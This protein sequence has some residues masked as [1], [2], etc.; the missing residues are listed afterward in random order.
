MECKF[1]I[2]VPVYKVEDYL[3][4]CVNS[5]RNQTLEEFELILVDDG[6]PDRSGELCDELASKDSRIRVVHQENQGLSGARNSGLPLARGEYV[7][8]LDSDD[9]YPQRD[10]LSELWQKSEDKD[11]V[12][13]NYARFTDHLLQ[14]LISFPELGEQ[15][16][17]AMLLEL[18][19]KNAF[20][21]SACTKAA[22]RRMLLD[23]GLSFESGTLSEDIEWS[24]KVMKAAK[25]IA[26]APEC[27]Y[28]YRVRSSSITHTVSQKQVKMQLR[29]V[30]KLTAAAPQGS[31]D[32]CDA[33]WSYTAFQYCTILINMRL[34]RPAIDREARLEIKK[35]SWLL[36]YDAN[37]IVKLVHM[38]HRFLGFEITG[39]LL[40]I[41]F[42]LFCK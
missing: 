8:F 4:D 9:F 17:D 33:Y 38:V 32:F 12:L 2:I 36:Q 30:Q 34:C 19:K 11:V 6:S 3:E 5:V 18:V 22:K 29:I 28:A 42:K 10:F 1:S 35:L 24:A 40:L 16:A 21:S 15:A 14:P 41:Y 37:R 27:I 31:Q 25:S 39:W 20:Q 26:L 13:F 23:N 7:L